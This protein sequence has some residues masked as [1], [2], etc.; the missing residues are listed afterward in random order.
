LVHHIRI[1]TDRHRFFKSDIKTRVRV[2]NVYNHIYPP[3]YQVELLTIGPD[4]GDPVLFCDLLEVVPVDGD[5]LH[6]RRLLDSDF[7]GLPG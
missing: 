6:F 7:T 2:I 5:Y 1:Y 4:V 3:T